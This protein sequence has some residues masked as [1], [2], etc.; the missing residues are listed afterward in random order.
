[1]RIRMLTTQ[2]GA[3]DGFTLVTYEAG[4]EYEF[5]DTPRGKDLVQAFLRQRWAELADVPPATAP[6]APPAPEVALAAVPEVADAAPPPP[7]PATTAM[8][9]GPQRRRR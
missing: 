7:P 8:P 6:S 4:L 2:R 3:A 5:P 1:M 9:Q